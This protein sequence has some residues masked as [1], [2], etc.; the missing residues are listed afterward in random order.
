MTQPQKMNLVRVAVL[1]AAVIAVYGNILTHGFVWDDTMVILDNPKL[2]SLKNIPSLFLSEDKIDEASGYYRPVTYLSF[3]LDRVLWGGNPLGFNLTNLLLHAGVAVAFYFA[4][5]G[6]FKRERYAFLA[7]LLFSLHPIANESVNFHAG[8]RNTLLCALFALLALVCHQKRRFPAAL[9]FFVLAALSKEF[10]LLMP[11]VFLACDRYLGEARPKWQPYAGYGLA[12][13]CYLALRAHVIASASTMATLAPANLLYLTPK[14]AVS[15]L[16]NLV[17]PFR[18]KTMYDIAPAAGVA[19]SIPYLLALGF[20]AALAWRF[21]AR[22]EILLALLWF[23]LF[24]LPVS[25]VL[26]LGITV[27]AD[28]YAYFSSMGFALALASLVELGDRAGRWAVGVVALI[29]CLC[30]G[31]LDLKRNTYWKDELSLFS[32]MV[33]DA[34]LMSIGYQNL[35]AYYQNRGDYDRGAQYILDACLKATDQR[36]QLTR[37]TETFW[38]M[39]KFDLALMVAN[40]KR[41]LEPENPH[42]Y[43]MLSRLYGELGDRQRQTSFHDQAL[44]LFPGTERVVRERA[45]EEFQEGEKLMAQGRVA[46]ATQRYRD[47]LN[48]DLDFVPALIRLGLV[49]LDKREFD[50]AQ[51]FLS[52]AAALEPLNPA[53]HYHLARLYQMQGKT[54]PAAPPSPPCPSP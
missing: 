44:K 32:Q 26:P 48:I 35:S 18:L 23:F 11:L 47:A 36:V 4:V 41:E 27:M 13:V 33:R 34:P 20:L 37:L 38:E 29:L 52:K 49:N 6:L 12:T 21:R 39:R 24:L 53:P 40:Q 51:R 15:Y 8:G 5:L 42:P 17:L 25:G 45:T 2:A 46:L 1:I 3:A 31:A 16:A 10:A 7:A 9:A 14:L 43:L 22:R 19:E 50:N 30:Y 28:R 54:A